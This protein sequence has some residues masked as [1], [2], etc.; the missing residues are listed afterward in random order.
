MLHPFTTTV[1]DPIPSTHDL[2]SDA[3]VIARGFDETPDDEMDRAAIESDR[4][5]AIAEFE[6][7]DAHHCR[8]C[9]DVA[10]GFVMGG[11]HIQLCDGCCVAYVLAQIGP[12]MVRE[13]LAD[14]TAAVA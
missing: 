14:M 5:A 12:A 8:E 4:I 13:A 7:Y 6:H 2:L 1:H 10:S 11:V 3:N 9:G